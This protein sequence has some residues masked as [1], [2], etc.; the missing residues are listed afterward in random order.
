M[1]KEHFFELKYKLMVQKI[2]FD[3]FQD[4]DFCWELFVA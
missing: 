1:I 3:V 4:V 2:D